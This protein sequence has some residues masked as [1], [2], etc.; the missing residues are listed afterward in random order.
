VPSKCLA[1]LDLAGAVIFWIAVAAGPIFLIVTG[2]S[3]WQTS[4]ALAAV[5]GFVAMRPVS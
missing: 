1:A 3:F 4:N 2:R 5:A